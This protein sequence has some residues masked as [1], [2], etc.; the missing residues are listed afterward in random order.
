M[1]TRLPSLRTPPIGFAHRGARAHAPENTLEAFRLA[2]RLGATGLESDVWLTA[3]G[4]AVLDHD[5][6]FG[7][8]LRFRRRTR[9]LDVRRAELPSHIPTLAELYEACGSDLEVSLDVKDP[10]AVPRV[11]E[12]ARAAGDVALGRLW[13]C[14]DDLDLLSSWRALDGRVRLVDSTRLARIKEGPERRAATLAARDIDAIN[15]HHADWTGGLTTLFHRFDRYAFA[16][17][18]QF[19]RVIRDVVA[20]GIDGVFSDHVDV[21][22]ESIDAATA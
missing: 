8:L 4:E 5:G 20:M 22:M 21:L 10:A 3:D 19:E 15:M 16:W 18:A 2:R 9:I 6:M 1:P 14:H 7:S 12:V 17:D 11:L 13:L